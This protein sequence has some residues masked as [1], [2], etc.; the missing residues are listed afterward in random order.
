MSEPTQPPATQ[1]PPA[2]RPT[3]RSP[4]LGLRSARPEA[5]N[6]NVEG[7]SLAGPLKGFGQMWQKTYAYALGSGSRPPTW[8]RSGRPACPT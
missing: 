5:G 4:W 2:T 7:R 8:S 3:G 1:P 6:L